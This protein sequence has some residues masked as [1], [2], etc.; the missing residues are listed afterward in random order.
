[1]QYELRSTG[2]VT[3]FDTAAV[4]GHESVAVLFFTTNP[5]S[6]DLA[7]NQGIHGDGQTTKPSEPWHLAQTEENALENKYVTKKRHFLNSLSKDAGLYR[8][9]SKLLV[10]EV[11]RLPGTVLQISHLLILP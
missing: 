7:S 8:N 5:A 11:C 3:L 6:P 9:V 2:R 1:M 4:F 10:R